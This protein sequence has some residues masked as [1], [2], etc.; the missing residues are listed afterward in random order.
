MVK[1]GHSFHALGWGSKADGW[2]GLGLLAF[3]SLGEGPRNLGPRALGEALS[4]VGAGAS[5]T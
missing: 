3:G 1:I 2:G 5:G 4:G